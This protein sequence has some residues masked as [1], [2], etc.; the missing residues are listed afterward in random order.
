MRQ[1]LFSA[2]PMRPAEIRK[3]KLSKAGCFLQTLLRAW[4]TVCSHKALPWEGK[5]ARGGAG[6]GRTS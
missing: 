5:G 4:A 3:E 6:E 1:A 2:M